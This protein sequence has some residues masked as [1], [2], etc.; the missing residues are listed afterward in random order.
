MFKQGD[1]VICVDAVDSSEQ[2]VANRGKA[3]RK[4]V[5][6]HC[7]QYVVEDCAEWFVKLE[8]IRG[9]WHESRFVLA[10]EGV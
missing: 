10:E 4:N 8:G 2:M 5:L 3:S 1:I 6:T 7:Q 9:E